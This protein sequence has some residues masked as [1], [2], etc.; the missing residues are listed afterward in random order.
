MLYCIHD[1]LVGEFESYSAAKCMRDQLSI[2]LDKT[3]SPLEPPSLWMVLPKGKR[4]RAI[5]KRKCDI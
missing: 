4:L 2:M 3:N 1:A 5:E